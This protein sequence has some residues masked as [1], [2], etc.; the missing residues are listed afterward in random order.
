M[1]VDY[2]K[3]YAC[4]GV[5]ISKKFAHKKF[6]QGGA[7]RRPWYYIQYIFTFHTNV[8]I[9]QVLCIKISELTSL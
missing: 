2:N 6:K 1:H 5:K 4:Y 9:C 8:I 3:V 7:R